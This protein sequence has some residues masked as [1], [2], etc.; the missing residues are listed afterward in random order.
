MEQLEGQINIFDIDYLKCEKMKAVNKSFHLPYKR[1]ETIVETCLDYSTIL[2]NLAE[3]EENAYKKQSLL[4]KAK[5]NLEI[6]TLIAE[7]IGYDKSC[8]K[9]KKKKDD[10]IG[11]D[12]L[13]LAINGYNR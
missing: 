9:S 4:L 6:S 2:N 11:A 13:E 10:D 8:S 12:A 3:N 5:E 7:N 1:L